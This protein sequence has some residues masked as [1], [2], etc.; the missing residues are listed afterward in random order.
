MSFSGG[1]RGLDP[2]QECNRMASYIVIRLCM[3]D[4]GMDQIVTLSRAWIT[5]EVHFQSLQKRTAALSNILHS[6][7]NWQNV[8]GSIVARFLLLFMDVL[9][10]PIPDFKWKITGN[11]SVP[12]ANDVLHSKQRIAHNRK[13]IHISKFQSTYHMRICWHITRSQ[14]GLCAPTMG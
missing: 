4:C 2:W 10:C 13:W 9:P 14:H 5:D 7:S 3:E 6:L 1:G 8:K 11:G 12:Q